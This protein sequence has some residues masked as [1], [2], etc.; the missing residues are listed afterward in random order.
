MDLESRIQQ[1]AQLIRSAHHMVAFTGAG[2]STPSGIPD[3]RSPG[4]GL[5]EKDNPML[6]AS[7]WAFRLNPKTFYRWIRPMVKTLLDAIPN[8]AHRALAEMEEMGVLKAVITQNID[9]LHQRAGSRRVLELHGHMREATCIRCYQL[10][11]IDPT[12]EQAVMSG[13]VPHCACGGILKP[14]VIL[15]G[16]QLPVR[17]LNAAMAEARRCDL[18]LVAGSSLEVTPAA[19]IPYLAVESG[20]RSIIVNLEPTGFDRL[21]EVVIHGDVAEILPRIVAAVAATTD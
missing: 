3:F 10:V 21:A 19:D 2:H 11:P 7:I 15:F 20:A 8:P 4:S 1:A 17:V 9:N 5:W 12:V 6:V 14:N 13:K 18:V 16:E